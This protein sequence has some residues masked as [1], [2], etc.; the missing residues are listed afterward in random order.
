[1]RLYVVHVQRFVHFQISGILEPTAN[2]K[3]S[4]PTSTCTVI[5]ITWSGGVGGRE[6]G[7]EDPALNVASTKS[8][9]LNL[10]APP[11]A[12]CR[13]QLDPKHATLKALTQNLSHRR[14]HRLHIKDERR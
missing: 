5:A 8:L 6:H 3:T 10:V 13:V 14:R 7:D 4:T 12:R 1:V 11:H 2:Q 9:V